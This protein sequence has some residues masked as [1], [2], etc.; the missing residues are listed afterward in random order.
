MSKYLPKRK[1]LTKRGSYT[2][3]AFKKA[4]SS[5]QKIKSKR[6]REREF[7]AI[8]GKPKKKEGYY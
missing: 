1:T 7:G 8:L 3:P 6:V 2:R 5:R 4:H